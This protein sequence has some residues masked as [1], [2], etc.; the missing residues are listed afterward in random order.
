MLLTYIA[1]VVLL[2]I[3][4]KAIVELTQILIYGTVPQKKNTR[5]IIQAFRR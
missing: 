1:I 5:K 3:M 2:L 4:L